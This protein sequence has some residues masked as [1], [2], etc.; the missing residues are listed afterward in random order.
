M[1]KYDEFAAAQE[2]ID[3]QSALIRELVGALRA[4]RAMN[5][6]ALDKFNWGA[7]AL[8]AKAITLLNESPRHVLSALALL[9]E[10]YRG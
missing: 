3:A 10:E 5:E 6:Y 1:S 7:S 4:A 9:P 2:T 8:D